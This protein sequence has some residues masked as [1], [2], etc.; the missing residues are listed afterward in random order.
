MS[1]NISYQVV[2]FALLSLVLFF[3]FPIILNKPKSTNLDLNKSQSTYYGGEDT[4]EQEKQDF[5]LDSDSADR[6]SDL[7]FGDVIFENLKNSEIQRKTTYYSSEFCIPESEDDFDYETYTIDYKDENSIRTYVN[8]VESPERF[9]TRD[10]QYL[11]NSFEVYNKILSGGMQIEDIKQTNFIPTDL[12]GRFCG[13]ISTLP[14]YSVEEIDYQG[15]DSAY[16]ILTYGSFQ[17]I[18]NSDFL[19]MYIGIIAQK[20]DTYLFI[21]TDE[22]SLEELLLENNLE[23][24]ETD[25]DGDDFKIIDPLSDTAAKDCVESILD[26]DLDINAVNQ[27]INR[28]ISVFEIFE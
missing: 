5:S 26:Q 25:F 16:F 17:S 10:R 14:I 11:T 22:F 7:S 23:K 20:E 1:N 9:I 3:F 12:F 2:F 15:A 4:D 27:E 19:P 24:C 6:L 21:G 13:G 8:I 28:M 18:T